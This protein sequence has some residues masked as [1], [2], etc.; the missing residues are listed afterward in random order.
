M[1]NI[2]ANTII[3]LIVSNKLKQAD[4]NTAEALEVTLKNLIKKFKVNSSNIIEPAI[5]NTETSY[6]GHIELDITFKNLEEMFNFVYDFT[7]SSFEIYSPE[8]LVIPSPTF[9]G[10]LNALTGTILNVTNMKQSLEFS[11]KSFCENVYTILNSTESK[12]KKLEKIE[13]QL[14]KYYVPARKK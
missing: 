13:E 11:L 6:T 10:E 12:P 7:P 14:I 3:T 4:K 9:T 2:K 1:E 5:D 8:T